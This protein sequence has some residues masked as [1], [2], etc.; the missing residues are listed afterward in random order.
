MFIRFRFLPLLM[1]A[2]APPVFAAHNTDTDVMA[3]KES[4][5]LACKAFATACG[6]NMYGALV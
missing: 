4:P 2:K 3:I 6:W 5:Q 1:P